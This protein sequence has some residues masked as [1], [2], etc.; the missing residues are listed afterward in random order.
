MPLHQHRVRVVLESG[1]DLAVAASVVVVELP[2]RLARAVDGAAAREHVAEGARLAPRGDADEPDAAPAV[3][4]R[5]RHYGRVELPGGGV[6]GKRAAS[7]GEPLGVPVH[8]L[9]DLVPHGRIDRIAARVDLGHRGG[10]LVPVALGL[11]VVP[12][13]RELGGGLGVRYRHG[14]EDRL[15]LLAHLRDAHAGQLPARTA[16]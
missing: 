14:L 11:H 5:V 7:P 2:G 12:L 6:P 15:H 1:S 9:A 16:A 4:R 3:A 10:E 13:R 8:E